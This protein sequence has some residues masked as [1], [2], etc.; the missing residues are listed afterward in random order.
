MIQIAIPKAFRHSPLHCIP[1]FHELGHF[2]DQE[3]LVTAVSTH[4][5]S[6]WL[7]EAR[8]FLPHLPLNECRD[9][10][11]SHRSELFADIFAACY[12]GTTNWQYLQSFSDNDI[13]SRTHPSLNARKKIALSF[14]R[15]H[16]DTLSDTFNVA[17]AAR[18]AR[19]SL[20][21]KFRSVSQFKSSLDDLRPPR[22]KSALNSYGLIREFWLY[23]KNFQ[24]QRPQSLPWQVI[25]PN[26]KFKIL[27]DLAEKSIRNF[28]ISEAW[29]R[30]VT[31]KT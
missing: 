2:I 5:N 26:D 15:R 22:S 11:I 19:G 21:R 3:L 28:F 1:L 23:Y 12:L 16:P 20:D 18:G 9:I 24:R 17:L 30:A 8:L 27:N 6:D 4:I 7:T 31:S 10:E 14:L 29:L 13:P 25:P